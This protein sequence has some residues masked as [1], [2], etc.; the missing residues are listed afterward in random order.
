ME[1]ETYEDG[2]EH[3][4]C[5]KCRRCVDCG[6]CDRLGCGAKSEQTPNKPKAL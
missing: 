4:M 5:P 6:D 1:N 3:F 2:S